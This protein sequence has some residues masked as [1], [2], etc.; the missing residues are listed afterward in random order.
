M[1]VEIRDTAPG[2]GTARTAYLETRLSR[3]LQPYDAHIEAAHLA[4]KDV[5]GDAEGELSLHRTGESEPMTFRSRARR[6]T[7]MLANLLESAEARLSI[8]FPR[9]R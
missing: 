6:L 8:A 3:I 1:H 7:T 5:D 2:S 4:L 9:P